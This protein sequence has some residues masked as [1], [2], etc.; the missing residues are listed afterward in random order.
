MIKVFNNIMPCS[1]FVI[2]GDY[3]EDGYGGGEDGDCH[4]RP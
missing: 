3:V 1:G 4:P 2:I